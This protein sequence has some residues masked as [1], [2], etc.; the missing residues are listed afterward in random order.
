MIMWISRYCGKYHYYCPIFSG[1]GMGH[2]SIHTGSCFMYPPYKQQYSAVYFVCLFIVCNF[3]F[4]YI[5]NDKIGISSLFV[6]S[7]NS[8]IHT[9]SSMKIFV[10][11][12]QW[13]VSDIFDLCNK[14]VFNVILCITGYWICFCHRQVLI[15]II[16]I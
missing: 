16:S 13:D 8:L 14:P 6:V 5:C 2:L 9:M 7:L 1:L 15:P 3:L 10:L 4:T 12:P 11:V